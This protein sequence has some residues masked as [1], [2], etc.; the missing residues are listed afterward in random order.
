MTTDGGF[1]PFGPLAPHVEA[2]L[3]ESIQRFGVLV[4]VYVDQH[5]VILDGHQRRRIAD[6]L[7][8]SYQALTY[9]CADD[10]E[11]GEIARTLNADRR[12]LTEEQ[13]REVALSLRQAGHSYRAIGG[14]LCVDPMTAMHDVARKIV[15]G[16]T[17]L[18]D[19]VIRQGGGSY[20]SERPPHVAYN[21]GENEWYTPQ[22]IVELAREV[23]GG[24]DLD[25]AS[26]AAANEVVGAARF[27]DAACDGLAQAWAGRVFMNPPYSSALIGK[28]C[29]KLVDH[30]RTAEVSAAIVLVNNATE[31]EWFGN[32][33]S[34]AVAVCFPS[35]RVRFW[36]PGRVA[37]PLQGQALV[38]IGPNADLFLCTFGVLGWT[39]R[40]A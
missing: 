7:G 19:R 22:E 4:P 35:S 17:I 34:V 14:A 2:A 23:L 40:I 13:R 32:L 30:V 29:S 12:H 10:A 24:I 18:P 27:F 37:A 38:Y 26:S 8:V 28:F 16:S 9:T 25:P 1:Q 15:D 3:R 11:R 5:G 20:P 31:T 33:V 39:A 6:E 21:T 36:S